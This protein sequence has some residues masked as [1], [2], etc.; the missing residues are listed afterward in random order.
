M[1]PEGVHSTI[2]R[3]LLAADEATRAAWEAELRHTRMAQPAIVLSSLARLRLLE[4]LGL[5]PT[6]VIHSLGEISALC[7]AGACNAATAVRIAALRGRAMADLHLED[8][9]AM[10]AIAADPDT[11]E[12]L[13]APFGAALTISNYNSPKQTV[14]SGASAAIEALGQVCM[15]QKIRCQRLPV[16]HAFHSALVAPAA[17]AFHEALSPVSFQALSGPVVSTATGQEISEDTDLRTLLGDH[18]RQ[19]V[20]FIDAALRAAQPQ[21]TLWIEVG[22]GGVLSNLVRDILG[23]DKVECL[24]TDLS[25]EEG[26]HLLNK[27]L[28]C[29]FVRGLP[30]ALDRLFAHRFSRLFP[31]DDYN[32]RFITNPGERPVDVSALPIQPAAS[33]LPAALLPAEVSQSSLTEYLVQRGPFLRDFIA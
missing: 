5:Q 20:R 27:V 31:L 30:L 23:A 18:I 2:F 33:V 15:E 7:A 13:L 10:V 16:S 19:P 28:V 3:D 26:F 24:P 11:V 12:K 17:M 1:L 29:A 6:L 8:P 4:F 21:P 14:V 9:G 25:G 22:P 32:P